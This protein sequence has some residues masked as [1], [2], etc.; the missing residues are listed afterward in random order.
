MTEDAKKDIAANIVIVALGGRKVVALGLCLAA[1]VWGPEVGYNTVA[2]LFTAF[3]G[4]NMW[5]HN[6]QKPKQ[7]EEDPTPGMWAAIE[8]ARGDDKPR[9]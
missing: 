1:V 5:E 7:V 2:M 9:S 4:G 3:V 6:T 8:E